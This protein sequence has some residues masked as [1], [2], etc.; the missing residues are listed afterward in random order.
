MGIEDVEDTTCLDTNRD[1]LLKAF[2]SFRMDLDNLF[3]IQNIDKEAASFFPNIC[4]K[5]RRDTTL[6]ACKDPSG[7]IARENIIPFALS[8]G[9]HYSRH[10][11]YAEV[12]DALKKDGYLHEGMT[13]VLKAIKKN[14]KEKEIL[15]RR[16]NGFFKE[17]SLCG[18]RVVDE[19]GTEGEKQLCQLFVP[20]GHV[21]KHFYNELE[22]LH[23]P[24]N[25]LTSQ[26]L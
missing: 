18:P 23:R 21:L 13:K 4:C 5:E 8:Q 9:G 16:I 15:Q 12:T 11:L 25:L 10:N 14:K 1:E 26:F 6:E 17:L 20:Y 3:H 2:C 7:T 24:S 22:G 19:P